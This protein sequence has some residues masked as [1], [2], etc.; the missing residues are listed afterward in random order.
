[1]IYNIIPVRYINSTGG[2]FISIFLKYARDNLPIE[3]KFSDHGNAHNMKRDLPD[4]Y[5]SLN[6]ESKQQII[7]ESD[8]LGKDKMYYIPLHYHSPYPTGLFFKHITIG[9]NIISIPKLIKVFEKKWAVDSE[10]ISSTEKI[11]S[12]I[13]SQYIFYIKNIKN[14]QP[15]SDPNILYLNWENDIL[16]NP[17][18]LIEKLS[19]FSFIK[20]ENF[21]I[22]SL[23]EWQNLTKNLFKK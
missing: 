5:H 21:D 22:E 12:L 18:S 7:N 13:K 6:E 3:K 20:K 14:Y 19:T 11:Q 8:K 9:Y 16:G 10:N 23:I 15:S 17:S 1:M 4:L 2:T